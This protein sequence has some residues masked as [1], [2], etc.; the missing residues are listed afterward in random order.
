MKRTAHLSALAATLLGGCASGLPGLRPLSYA[1]PGEA[2]VFATGDRCAHEPSGNEAAGLVAA[3]LTGAA[4]QL[5]KNFGTALSEGAKGGALPASTAAANLELAPGTVP[6]CLVVIRGAFQPGGLAVPIDL[7]R[8][9]GLE[10]GGEAAKRLSSL[11]IPAV[12]RIDHYVEIKV[13][14][15][16]SSKALTFA[17]THVRLVRSIDGASRGERDMSIA[18]KFGRVGADATG[19]AVVVADRRIGAP[20]FTWQAINRR[21]LIEAPWFAS[22]H[23]APSPAGTAAAAAPAPQPARQGAAGPRPGGVVGG[24]GAGPGGQIAGPP[25]GTPAGGIV[26]MSEQ[27]AGSVPTTVTVTIV[28]TRPTNEALAFVAAVFGGLQPKIEEK[29]KTV[30]DD[31][32]RRTADVAEATGQLDLEAAYAAA[33]GTAQAAVVSYC[34]AA[35]GDATPAGRTDRITKSQAARSAQIKA[36]AAAIK[37]DSPQP[38]PALAKISAG[39]PAQANPAAC[40]AN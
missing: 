15:S 38:Y 3:A 6:R 11:G 23:A 13:M 28:E 34:E 27:G 10:P 14:S 8:W 29:L 7:V 18:V 12:Y 37:A 40:A 1:T 36:N 2:H 30:I 33:L 16:A 19:S 24:G 32:A 17:P 20:G 22:F 21:Y 39:L 31:D 5:L 26:S 9:L 4:S 25:V 35:S